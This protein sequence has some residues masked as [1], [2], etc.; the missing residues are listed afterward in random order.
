VNNR[1]WTK[2]EENFLVEKWGKMKV[3]SISKKINRTEGAIKRK[4]VRL[5][6][7]VQMQ[8]YSV[9]EVAYMFG[10]SRRKVIFLIETGKISYLRDK[11]KKK[12]YMIDEDSLM[13]F[14][15]EYQNLWD[16]RKL[17]IN[18]YQKKPNWFKEKEI[19]DKN[20]SIK[21]HNYWSEYETK[22]LIDRYHKGWTL[23]AIAEEIGRSKCSVKNKLVK[24][25][26]GRKVTF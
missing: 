21:K 9:N 22:I 23:E 18:I 13:K 11:T 25:D 7:G 26:Y 19:S 24:I 10:F 6:L 16:T 5:N 17:T 1:R 15:K 4:A 12:R 14:M 20:I 2:E 3:S 8:W